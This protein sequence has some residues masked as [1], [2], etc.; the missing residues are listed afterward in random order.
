[1]ISE[2]QRTLQAADALAAGDLVLMG[3]LMAAS[4]ASMRDDFAITVPHRYLVGIVKGSSA[5]AAACV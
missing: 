4:H 1:M 2:N 5:I 3:E